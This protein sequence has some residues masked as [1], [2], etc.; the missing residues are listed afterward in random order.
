MTWYFSIPVLNS[1]LF[2]LPFTLLLTVLIRI[3]WTMPQCSIT[4]WNCEH[5]LLTTQWIHLV[6]NLFLYGF[7][8]ETR[9]DPIKHL[10]WT[11]PLLCI[12]NRTRTCPFVLRGLSWHFLTLAILQLWLVQCLQCVCCFIFSINPKTSPFW[13][14]SRL[15]TVCSWRWRVWSLRGVGA[16]VS[17]CT[18]AWDP[19][20]R[21]CLHIQLKMDAFCP[22]DPTKS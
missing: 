10:W 19:S 11:I 9:P 6:S 22:P 21:L 20:S 7:L 1:G 3:P 8:P 4:S 16:P 15:I 13:V 14:I 18:Y 2:P 12:E 17:S 5:N